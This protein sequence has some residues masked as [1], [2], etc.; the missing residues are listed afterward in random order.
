MFTNCFLA[1]KI[2]T[3]LIAKKKRKKLIEP[4][5]VCCYP[6]GFLHS[7]TQPHIRKET[8]GFNS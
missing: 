4:W 1:K 2:S 5:I 3:V 7:H 6:S 8:L